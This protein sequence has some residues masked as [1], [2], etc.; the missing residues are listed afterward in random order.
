MKDTTTLI[1]WSY[2]RQIRSQVLEVQPSDSF[3]NDIAEHPKQNRNCDTPTRPDQSRDKA[4][5]RNYWALAVTGQQ[6]GRAQK[7]QQRP[8]GKGEW[9]GPVKQQTHHGATSHTARHSQHQ[10]DPFGAN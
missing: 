1:K 2:L 5:S 3:D 8:D 10:F 4:V 6:V 9:M 7:Q